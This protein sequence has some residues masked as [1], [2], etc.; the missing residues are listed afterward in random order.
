MITNHSMSNTQILHLVGLLNF[1][2]FAP[3]ITGDNA[4]VY[5]Y[6]GNFC[7]V[8]SNVTGMNLLLWM[9]TDG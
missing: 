1:F 4:V 9:K 8:E 7:A 3:F 6:S 2:I 5:H